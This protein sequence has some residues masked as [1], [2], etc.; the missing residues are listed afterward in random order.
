MKL[1]LE[2]TFEELE[3]NFEFIVDLCA[4]NQQP[5]RIT[6]D[7]NNYMLIPVIEK[8]TINPE[9]V[10][11]IEELKTEWMQQMEAKSSSE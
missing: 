3:K 10:D 9:I 6:K 11:Q 7:G 1:P 8:T 2:I 4:S 5:F